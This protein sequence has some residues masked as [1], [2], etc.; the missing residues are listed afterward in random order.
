MSPAEGVASNTQRDKSER[1]CDERRTQKATEV[2]TFCHSHYYCF[3]P[4]IWIS[5]LQ[6]DADDD[7]IHEFK[8]I[9]L[10]RT[11]VDIHLFLFLARHLSLSL[12]IYTCLHCW[13]EYN[14][15]FLFLSF[16]EMIIIGLTLFFFL[17]W[18]C[19]YL[20]WQSIN[21]FPTVIAFT[22][23]N[24]EWKFLRQ[25]H[26]CFYLTG[27]SWSIRYFSSSDDTIKNILD[28]VDHQPT[29]AHFW[30][31]RRSID[32]GMIDEP[33]RFES[34]RITNEWMVCRCFCE[35]WKPSHSWYEMHWTRS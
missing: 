24:N 19:H 8:N 9:F 21:V 30:N 4:T 17:F 35:A 2:I 6:S 14:W 22:D 20:F 10:L 11:I 3:L 5:H 34:L 32:R 27:T 16:I 33:S 7:Q 26:T 23:I 15:F 31:S 28:H 1:N 25:T 12:S 18:L 13:H 29:R